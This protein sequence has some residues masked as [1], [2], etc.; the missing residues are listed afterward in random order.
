MAPIG[1]VLIAR[2][3]PLVRL[4]RCWLRRRYARDVVKLVFLYTINEVAKPSA[5]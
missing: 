2:K 5:S 4:T 3:Y 1:G